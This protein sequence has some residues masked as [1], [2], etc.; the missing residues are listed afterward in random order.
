MN[1]SNLIPNSKRTPEELRRMTSNGGKKSGEV[2]RKKKVLK[3]RMKAL[4]EMPVSDCNDLDKALLMGIN[5][6]EIDNETLLVVALFE[7]A[8]SGNVKAFQEI[9]NLIGQDNATEELK[10]KKKELTLRE[11]ALTGENVM[12]GA[13]TIVDDIKKVE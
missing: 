9:R 8:K 2:R 6:T 3:E 10:I 12:G 5:G 11:R 13:V 4:L 1:E 7:Q